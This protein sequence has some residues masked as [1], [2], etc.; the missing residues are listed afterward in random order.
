MKS[1][2]PA[3]CGFFS[4]MPR[5]GIFTQKSSPRLSFATSLDILLANFILGF[6]NKLCYNIGQIHLELGFGAINLRD[7]NFSQIVYVS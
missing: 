4:G 7:F 6:T 1:A 2:H 5:E 3:V